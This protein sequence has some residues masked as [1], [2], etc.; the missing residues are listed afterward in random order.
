MIER[1]PSYLVLE[2]VGIRKILARPWIKSRIYGVAA[3]HRG[4]PNVNSLHQ[5]RTEI[6]N[7]RRFS[8]RT[9]T[10]RWYLSPSLCIKIFIHAVVRF[11]RRGPTTR[12]QLFERTSRT[13]LYIFFATSSPKRGVKCHSGTRATI[14]VRIIDGE[15]LHGRWE[16]SFRV[17]RAPKPSKQSNVKGSRTGRFYFN[18]NVDNICKFSSILKW[19]KIQDVYIFL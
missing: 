13:L 8:I 5:K 19:R 10:I 14:F 17:S 12:N 11:P 2:S 3:A 7:V 1:Q 18:E 9:L 15:L 6:I 4:R 16:S